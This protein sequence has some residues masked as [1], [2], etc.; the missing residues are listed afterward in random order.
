MLKIIFYFLSIVGV[1]LIFLLAF[2]IPKNPFQIIPAI[3]TIGF[4]KP[5]WLCIAICGNFIYLLIIW[6]IY[7]KILHKKIA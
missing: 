4:D 1:I 3:T 5:L 2:T 6:S 7:D